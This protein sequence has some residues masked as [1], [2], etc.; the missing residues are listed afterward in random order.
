MGVITVVAFHESA[1]MDLRKNPEYFLG[2]LLE[3]LRNPMSKSSGEEFTQGGVLCLSA[4]Y[5]S[6]LYRD[7]LKKLEELEESHGDLIRPYSF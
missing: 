1:Y 6:D 4:R 5:R 3:V 7:F 2:K